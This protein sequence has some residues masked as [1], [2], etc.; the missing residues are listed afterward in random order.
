MKRLTALLLGTALLTTAPACKGE[1]QHG[2]CLG[3]DDDE[4]R[5]PNLNYDISVRNAVW[6]VLGFE[7]VIAPI[8]FFTD[9]AYCP[10]SRKTE[11]PKEEEP[12]ADGK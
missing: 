6:S 4:D 8:L 12:P 11:P 9:Y 2:E 7:T 10:E 3:F 5:D 1:T